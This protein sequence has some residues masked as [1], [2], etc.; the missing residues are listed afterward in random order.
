MYL[1][2][3]IHIIFIHA[4]LFM[5]ARH[6]ILACSCEADMLLC[7]WLFCMHAC[8]TNVWQLAHATNVWPLAQISL[9]L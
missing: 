3:Y 8:E 4:W 6:R 9:S 1:Y 2:V 7:V 5:H